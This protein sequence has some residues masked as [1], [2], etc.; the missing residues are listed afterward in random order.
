MFYSQKSNCFDCPQLNINFL[1][2]NQIV[3]YTVSK[4]DNSD[5]Y[6]RTN[7]DRKKRPLRT[8]GRVP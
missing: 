2:E 5:E 4:K 1:D 8:E 3:N 6:Q 7:T